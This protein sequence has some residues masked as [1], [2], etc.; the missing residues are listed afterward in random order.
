MCCLA[1]FPHH[2]PA[3]S[4]ALC[5]ESVV[6]PDVQC[7]H[8]LKDDI[9]LLKKFIHHKF[10]HHAVHHIMCFGKIYGSVGFQS[11]FEL[12]FFLSDCHIVEMFHLWELPIPDI[13]FCVFGYNMHLVEK[14][15]GRVNIHYKHSLKPISTSTSE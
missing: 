7:R 1:S 10:K 11:I 12:G 9:K 4:D 3:A 14:R 5:I 2:A 6:V 13:F 8:D 15:V